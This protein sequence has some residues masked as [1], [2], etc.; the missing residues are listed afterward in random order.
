MKAEK[1]TI[2]FLIKNMLTKCSIKLM[3][4]EFSSDIFK[5]ENIQLGYIKL[6]Y[7]ANEITIN[8]I[9]EKIQQLGLDIIIDPEEKLIE[10]IKLAIFELIHEMNNAS[11]IAKK[12]EYLVEKLNI[13]YQR[14][15]KL[16]SKHEKITLERYII[17]NKIEKIKELID[18]NEYTLS[19]IAY[20]M[21]YSSVQYLSNQFKKETGFSVSEYKTLKIKP[22]FSIEELGKS[23]L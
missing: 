17:L 19:E 18:S 1:K 2:E 22:K 14:M 4:R 13:S 21:D 10:E 12:S 23:K 20:L 15:S 5:I 9:V 8:G 16:F 3:Q 6:K 7:D 11:S